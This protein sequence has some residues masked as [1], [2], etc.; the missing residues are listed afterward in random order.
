[1]KL[2]PNPFPADDGAVKKELFVG[3][4]EI[5][6]DF[7]QFLRSDVGMGKNAFWVVTGSRGQ[8]KSSLLEAF[9]YRALGKTGVALGAW[10]WPPG[11]LPAN[12]IAAELYRSIAT[13][14][15]APSAVSPTG[16]FLF[17]VTTWIDD[18]SINLYFIKVSLQRYRER[19]RNAHGLIQRLASNLK[20]EIEVVAF[21][22]DEVSINSED[23]AEQT[24]QFAQAIA[25]TKLEVGQRRLNLLTVAFV[26]PQHAQLLST[27][28]G[29]PRSRIEF[30]L[31]DFTEAEVAEVVQKGLKL[32]EASDN[33]GTLSVTGEIADV[34]QAVMDLTGGVP[35]LAL[36]L[37]HDG[38]RQMEERLT[39]SN[40]TA[41]V[42]RAADVLSSRKLRGTQV[43]ARLA[44]F[45]F[46]L[47][48]PDTEP[49][50]QHARALLEALASDT[51][52]D[53]PWNLGALTQAMQKRI[54]KA[55]PPDKV[56]N[57][58]LAA[59][60]SAA[61]IVKDGQTIR[62]RGTILRQSLASSK[63]Y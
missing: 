41:P 47:H 21:L 30:H 17:K 1:M 10:K 63:V 57:P 27:K 24:K 36:G 39:T 45:Q 23:S 49:I 40:G 14:D 2:P 5:L 46:E 34:A 19:L 26:Q 53:G 58:I 56:I 50:K 25:D 42:M 35:T 7:D 16:R 8:G 4:E 31:Q 51:F 32:C 60:Q 3:R 48:L 37:L 62:F 59:L 61:L 33:E 6:D 9:R 22:V 28:S 15:K 12:P 43:D 55:A 54:G 13:Q 18:L 44:Q 11:K 38:Y 29:G 20:R 52:G